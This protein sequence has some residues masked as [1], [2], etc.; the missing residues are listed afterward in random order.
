M[1]DGKI[2]VKNIEQVL[3]VICRIIYK[4]LKVLFQILAFIIEKLWQTFNEK[5]SP[6]RE[7]VFRDNIKITSGQ[8]VKRYRVTIKGTAQNNGPLPIRKTVVM[9]E[10]QA[11]LFRGAN[12]YEAIEGWIHANYPGAKISNIRDFAVEIKLI[13]S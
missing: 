5:P 12:R 7:K 10:K 6:K 1:E 3:E 13:E 2:N 9:D 4:L 8:S 11:K